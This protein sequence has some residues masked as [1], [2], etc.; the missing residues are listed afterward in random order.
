MPY[1]GND[2]K[3]SQNVYVE[4]DIEVD[5][6]GN[7]SL[8]TFIYQDDLDDPLQSRTDF[9]SVIENLID[10]YREDVVPGRNQIYSI[11]SELE[12]SAEALRRAADNADTDYMSSHYDLQYFDDD[13]E[14]DLRNLIE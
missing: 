3:I 8:V 13:D 2:I 9:D 6:Q 7:L 4:N 14:Q 5:D 1:T 11:A 10:Y 12:R